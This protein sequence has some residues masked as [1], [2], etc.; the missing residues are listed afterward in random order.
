MYVGNGTENI[1][2]LSDNTYLSQSV[3]E[4]LNLITYTHVLF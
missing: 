4:A 1:S 3:H 2:K